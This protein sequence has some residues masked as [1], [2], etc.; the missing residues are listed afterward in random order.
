MF[1]RLNRDRK[2]HGLPPLEYDERLADVARFHATDMRDHEFFAHESPNTGTLEDR[3]NRASYLFLTARENLVEAPD[4]Q[5]GEDSLLRSPGHFANIMASDITHIGIGLVHGGVQAPENL[6]V[7]QV[8]ASRSRAESPAQARATLI[9]QI[10]RVRAQRGLGR[11][12]VHPL[13][14]ELA[15]KH[16]AELDA[17][18]SPS[19]LKAVSQRVSEDVVAAK[20]KGLKGV[21]ATAQLLPDTRSFEAPDS[22]AGRSKAPFGLAVRKISGAG[23]RPMVQVLLLVGL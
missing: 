16:I 11:A 14:N 5:S 15:Q 10:Q 17:E 9:A 19:S 13:L 7:T 8:F 4:V 23:G 3:L 21:G 18:T 12:E 6:T 22:L 1:Q 2:E 20:P